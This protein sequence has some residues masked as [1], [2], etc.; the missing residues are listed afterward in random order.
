MQGLVWNFDSKTVAVHIFVMF[1]FV[2]WL[3]LYL[4]NLANKT[5]SKIWEE[6][7]YQSSVQHCMDKSPGM[8]IF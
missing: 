7:H 6:E 4:Y 8:I 1:C 5:V 3:S 2:L